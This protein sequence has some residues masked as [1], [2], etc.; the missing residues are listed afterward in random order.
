MDADWNSPVLGV[1]GPEEGAF[2]PFWDCS[3]FPCGS[4]PASS[5]FLCCTVGFGTLALNPEF[6]E[7]DII[8][9][10]YLL[11]MHRDV[12]ALEGLRG[13]ALRLTICS[14]KRRCSYK[15]PIWESELDQTPS[16]AGAVPMEICDYYGVT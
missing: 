13:L 7:Q 11:T 10:L 1:G 9:L 4:S 12:F 16:P 2:L 6:H 3:F 14:S 15:Q 5:F 8:M